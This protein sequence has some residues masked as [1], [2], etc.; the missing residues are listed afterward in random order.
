[1]N[2]D[3]RLLHETAEVVLALMPGWRRSAIATTWCT[4]RSSLPGKPRRLVRLSTP[5]HRPTTRRACGSVRLGCA[6]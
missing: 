3:R 2:G 5:M 1:M 6:R 4:R